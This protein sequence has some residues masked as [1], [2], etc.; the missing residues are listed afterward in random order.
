MPRRFYA[1]YLF[2]RCGVGDAMRSGHSRSLE[3]WLACK[4]C[5]ANPIC[6][7]QKPLH[8]VQTEQRIARLVPARAGGVQLNGRKNDQK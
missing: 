6:T 3:S 8:E 4:G 7:L 5:D 1:H 2:S